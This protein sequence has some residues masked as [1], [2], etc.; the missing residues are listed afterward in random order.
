M[1]VEA[2]SEKYAGLKATVGVHNDSE[3]VKTELEWKH[4]R[5]TVTTGLDLF[6]PK[7]TT[8]S[9]TGAVHHEGISLGGSAEYFI[10]DRQELRKFDGVLAYTSSD[11][12]LTVYSQRKG[13]I[14]G[15][16]IWKKISP[17]ANIAADLSFDLHKTDVTPKLTFGTSYALDAFGTLVKAKFDTDGKASFSYGQRLNS[18]T[19]AFVGTTINTN[20]LGASGNHTLGFNFVFDI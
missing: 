15:G 19:K 14:L 11:L 2:T 8:L 10:A 5:A 16:K 9:A 18:F 7:G 4:E 3:S 20:N 13:D 6:S 17:V 12:Q 1:K